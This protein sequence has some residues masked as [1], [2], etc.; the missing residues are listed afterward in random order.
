MRM[1]CPSCMDIQMGG[2]LFSCGHM[3]TTGADGKGR[4]FELDDPRFMCSHMST[5]G[6]PA[7]QV[8]RRNWRSVYVPD[9]RVERAEQLFWLIF[10]GIVASA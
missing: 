4:P 7:A 9:L 6:P 10:L 5:V 8:A 2:A 1:L 3:P